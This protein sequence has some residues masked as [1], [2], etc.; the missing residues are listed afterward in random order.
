MSKEIWEPIPG[1]D[2]TA[3]VSSHGRIRVFDVKYKD[4]QIEKAIKLHKGGIPKIYLPVGGKASQ[5]TVKNLVA[6]AH[7]PNPDQCRYVRCIDGDEKNVKASN[8]QW[9]KTH[10]VDTKYKIANED[11]PMIRMRREHGETYR[12]IA[13]DY[14]ISESY[15]AKLCN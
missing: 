7:V 10:G 13:E 8:L 5:F 9:S 12:A 4:Y 14:G 15:V 2:I 11:V 3:D 6:V 1:L